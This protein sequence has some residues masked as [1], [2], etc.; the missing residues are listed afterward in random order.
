MI[1]NTRQILTLKYSEVSDEIISSHWYENGER[2]REER[3]T[4]CMSLRMGMALS[5]S[6]KYA[7]LFTNSPSGILWVRTSYMDLGW[8][9]KADK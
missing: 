5:P 8:V 2:E 4:M 3:K 1:P 7:I 6:L 9:G